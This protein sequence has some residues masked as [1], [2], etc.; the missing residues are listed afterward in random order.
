MDLLQDKNIY[1]RAVQD[2]SRAVQDSITTD[3]R[4]L[5]LTKN[6]K[7]F[8]G[9]WEKNIHSYLW[10]LASSF[11]SAL[12]WDTYKICSPPSLQNSDTL[13]GMLTMTHITEQLGTHLKSNWTQPSWIVMICDLSLV[14]FD[15]R[16]INKMKINSNLKGKLKTY[17]YQMDLGKSQ[18]PD[19]L[20]MSCV[21]FGS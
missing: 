6:S 1:S 16:I 8:G 7:I 10:E 19:S 15:K 11:E 2:S 9:M 3:A 14:E 21:L 13:V 12:I 20:S 18:L 5:Q 17:T 4:I